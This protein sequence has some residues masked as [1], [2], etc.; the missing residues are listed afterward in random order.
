MG[1]EK[2]SGGIRGKAYHQDGGH[3]L[4]VVGSLE[5]SADIILLFQLKLGELCLLLC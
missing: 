5:A 2:G 1:G 3:V 4:C